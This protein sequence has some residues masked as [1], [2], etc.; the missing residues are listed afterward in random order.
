MRLGWLAIVHLPNHL[1][2]V[3][4]QVGPVGEITENT[5]E[6]VAQVDTSSDASVGS[7]KDFLICQE[8]LAKYVAQD[9]GGLV[10]PGNALSQNNKYLLDIDLLPTAVVEGLLLFFVKGPVFNSQR[11]PDRVSIQASGA[12]DWNIVTSW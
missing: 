3:L 10:T 4:L 9:R 8:T 7:Q 1:V 6:G 12:Q 5:A 2:A 11:L